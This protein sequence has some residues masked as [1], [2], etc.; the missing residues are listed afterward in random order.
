M[1]IELGA[2]CASGMSLSWMGQD[3]ETHSD[4]ACWRETH[5]QSISRNLSGDVTKEGV[6]SALLLLLALKHWIFVGGGLKIMGLVDDKQWC[7]LCLGKRCKDLMF[8]ALKKA[9]EEE[10]APAAFGIL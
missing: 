9:G 8:A 6:G 3:R 4:G 5:F 1:G 2:I 10:L 7:P